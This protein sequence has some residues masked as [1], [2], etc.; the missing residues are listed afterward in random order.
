MNPNIKVAVVSASIFKDGRINQYILDG[1]NLI[2]FGTNG[3]RRFDIS[4]D[5]IFPIYKPNHWVMVVI[6]MKRSKI[7]YYDPY[8]DFDNNVIRDV[9]QWLSQFVQKHKLNQSRSPML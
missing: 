1:G 6:L 9:K 4:M 2:Y 7:I 3:P 8:H 5:I